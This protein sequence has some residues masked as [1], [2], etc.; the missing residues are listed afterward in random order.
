M[1]SGGE[2]RFQQ[3]VVLIR[4]VLAVITRIVACYVCHALLQIVFDRVQTCF[5]NLFCEC[6]KELWR[7]E[8]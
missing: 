2:W 4:V 6:P 7:V 1:E 5:L 3:Y 8:W